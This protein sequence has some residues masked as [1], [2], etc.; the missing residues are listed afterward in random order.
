M[1]LY[2]RISDNSYPKQKLPGTNKNTCLLNFLK[3]FRDVIFSKDVLDGKQKPAMTIIADRCNKAT[4]EIVNA[5]G[6]PVL[7]TNLGNAGSVHYAID[8]AIKECHDGELVY[9][10]EDDYLHLSNAPQLLREGISHSDYVTLYDH[11]DKYTNLYDMGETSKV[12]R[13]NS[14]HWKY[15]ISTCMTF[16]T[17]V[18]TLKEDVEVFKKHVGVVDGSANHPV[19]HDIFCELRDKGRKLAVCIPGAACHTDLTFSGMVGALM[20]EPWA[21]QTMIL[22]LEDKLKN[23]EKRIQPND[24]EA[25][26][27]LKASILGNKTNWDK[28]VGLDALLKTCVEN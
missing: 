17:K 13:T 2:Y 25:F 5:T 7:T 3:S 1:R 12:T 15:T 20:I 23:V 11:P 4:M 18:S 19:D 27:A 22:E 8:L 26:S 16:G 14:S 6:L 24:Q 10:C 9:I 28:L 21:V